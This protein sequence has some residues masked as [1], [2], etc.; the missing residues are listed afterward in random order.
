[1]NYCSGHLTHVS[2][3]GLVHL[4][5]GHLT[6]DTAANICFLPLG[7][8]LNQSFLWT[9]FTE[10]RSRM[11]CFALS[12]RG[13]FAALSSKRQLQLDMNWREG[14]GLPQTWKNEGTGFTQVV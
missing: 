7:P 2:Y 9:R 13:L 4:L 6:Q 5:S 8:F 14:N 11:E 10:P 1:M 12:L 3:F